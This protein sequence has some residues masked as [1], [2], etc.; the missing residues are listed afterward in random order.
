MLRA[1][2]FLIL[3]QFAG[4]VTARAAGLTMPGPVLGLLLLLGILA[5]RGGP[6]EAMR[7]TS[8]GLLRH[9]SLL[10]VPAGVGVITQLDALGR[11]LLAI[12]VAIV[13]STALGLAVTALVM[14]RLIR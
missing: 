7:S 6:D 13:V 9:L 10:F 3:C 14:Q 4:E 2:T 8:T 5:V 11:D 1:L 12:G